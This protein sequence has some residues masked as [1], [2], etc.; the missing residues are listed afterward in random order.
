[1]DIP[2]RRRVIVAV[3]HIV[4]AKSWLRRKS[5][6]DND[7]WHKVNPGNMIIGEEPVEVTS[8]PR[9]EIQEVT[10]MDITAI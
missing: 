5:D 8:R 10:L 4:N 1:M 7:E 6:A 3:T 2:A 9:R